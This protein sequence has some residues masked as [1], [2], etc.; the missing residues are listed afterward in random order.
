VRWVTLSHVHLDRAA[1]PWLVRRFVDPEATFEYVGWGHPAAIPTPG[2]IEIPHGATPLG[3]PGVELGLHDEEGT[4]FSKVLR[5]YQLDDPALWRMERLIASG[6]SDTL[7]LPPPPNQTEEERTIGSSLNKLG[8][9]FGLAFDDDEHLEHTMPLY[10]AVYIHC[11]VCELPEEV[12]AEAPALPPE[13]TP[14]LR[15]AMER[16]KTV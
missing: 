2:S 12:L 15:A 9:A 8:T 14:Y 5:V 16:A 11:R 6:V 3:I 13:R 1:A 4:C 10:D 7:G